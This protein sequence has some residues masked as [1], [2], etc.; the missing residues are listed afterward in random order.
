M[1]ALFYSSEND[2][3]REK[4][5]PKL[6]Y[7]REIPKTSRNCFAKTRN[8]N[9]NKP[10]NVNPVICGQIASIQE[11]LRVYHFN[12]CKLVVYCKLVL[13]SKEE[14]EEKINIKK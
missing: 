11:Y 13:L 2:P 9:N 4:K 8:R 10:H 1:R 6:I 12:W 7:F 14:E 3:L 5:I